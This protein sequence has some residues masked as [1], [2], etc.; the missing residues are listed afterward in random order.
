MKKFVKHIAL[1]FVVL[2]LCSGSLFAQSSISVFGSLVTLNAPII[3]K[4]FPSGY[5]RSIGANA[6][7]NY[8]TRNLNTNILSVLYH[9]VEADITQQVSPVGTPVFSAF[10]TTQYG[11]DTA[12]IIKYL[13]HG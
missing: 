12:S 11:N 6:V 1:Y 7:R 8:T 3:K 4:E 10:F 2:V 5:P 9:T 13:T